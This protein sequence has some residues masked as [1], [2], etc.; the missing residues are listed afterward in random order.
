[1][2]FLPA[3]F[4]ATV[5]AMPIMEWE[6][7]MGAIMRPELGLYFGLSVPITL[8]IFIAWTCLTRRRKRA[9]EEEEREN[10]EALDQ[11]LRRRS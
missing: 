3:T 4:L 9:V 5:F 10:K 6:Q 1:M 2:A 11:H 8:G 7:G